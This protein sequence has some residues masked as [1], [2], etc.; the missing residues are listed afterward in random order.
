MAKISRLCLKQFFRRVLGH[1]LWTAIA[2]LLRILACTMLTI[3]NCSKRGLLIQYTHVDWRAKACAI[4]CYRYSLVLWL[5]SEH[6]SERSKEN[7]NHP[8]RA[9]ASVEDA[10]HIFILLAI[11]ANENIANSH[12]ETKQNTGAANIWSLK[13]EPDFADKYDKYL[14]N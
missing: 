14:H 1:G 2:R 7:K 11:A 6:M 8:L 3:K 10:L 9:L 13:R 5:C 4:L 12:Y